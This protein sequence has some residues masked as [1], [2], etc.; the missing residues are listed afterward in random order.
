MSSPIEIRRLGPADAADYRAIRLA[1]LQTA[2]AA[3]GSTYALEAVRPLGSFEEC[4]ASSIVLGAYSAGRIVG[5]AGL[6]QEQG[7]KDAHKAFVWGVFVDPAHRRR[8]IGA[9]LLEALIAAGRECVEQ[10]T[11]AV[12]DENQAAIALYQQAGF[13]AYG[14]EPRALKTQAGYADEVL[15]W[16][17]LR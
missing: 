9:A 15:M 14:V 3:F 17:R 11:L 6:K 2:S 16:L 8:N 5:M 7:A 10:L 1:A 13:V 12:V 4:L